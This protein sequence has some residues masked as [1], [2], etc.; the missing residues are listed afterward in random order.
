MGP[1]IDPKNRFQQQCTKSSFRK[2]SDERSFQP[3]ENH[4]KLNVIFSNFCK[5]V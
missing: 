5:Y 2:Q 1:I 4:F 3:F